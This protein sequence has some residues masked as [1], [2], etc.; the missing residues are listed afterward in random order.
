MYPTVSPEVLS[1]A[2]Q[3]ALYAVTAFAAFLSVMLGA[4]G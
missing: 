1:G 4:R 3:M 2:V